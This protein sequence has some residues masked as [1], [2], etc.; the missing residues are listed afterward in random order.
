MDFTAQL[1]AATR[2]IDSWLAYKVYADRLPGLTI[3]IVHN[4]QIIFTKGYGY[5]NI[6]TQTKTTDT[7]S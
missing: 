3:G 5:A 2:L 6:E 7:T 1:S 4:D